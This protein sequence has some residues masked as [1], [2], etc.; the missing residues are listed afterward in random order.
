VKV[1]LH[2]VAK[3]GRA[4]DLEARLR[5]LG[6]EEIRILPGS[7]RLVLGADAEEIGERLGVSLASSERER[8]V[9]PATKRVKV[10]EV[11]DSARLPKDL[12]RLVERWYVPEPPARLGH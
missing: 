7:D 8:K 11:P 1:T 6:F 4:G 5:K 2:F 9:G 3:P 10:A 12:D